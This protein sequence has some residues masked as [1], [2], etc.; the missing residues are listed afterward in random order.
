MEENVEDALRHN[1]Q[2]LTLTD[3]DV[4]H[5]VLGCQSDQKRVTQMVALLY[6]LLAPKLGADPD[7]IRHW[8]RTQNRHLGAR[9]LDLLKDND[10]FNEVLKYLSAVDSSQSS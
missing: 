4:R 2:L 5:I 9:P 7:A 10:G 8:L 6:R 3:D 1:A